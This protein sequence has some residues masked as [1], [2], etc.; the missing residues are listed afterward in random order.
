M[1]CA[2][3]CTDQKTGERGPEPLL[4]LS[5]M[6][7]GRANFG[8]HL[9]SSTSSDDGI[10]TS[11]S[12]L[13]SSSVPLPIV[14]AQQS[15]FTSLKEKVHI[16]TIKHG[17][18]STGG[19]EDQP[20]LENGIATVPS[21]SNSVERNKIPLEKLHHRGDDDGAYTLSPTTITATTTSVAKEDLQQQRSEPMMMMGQAAPTAGSTPATKNVQNSGIKL[22]NQQLSSNSSSQPFTLSKSSSVKLANSSISIANQVQAIHIGDPVS[23]RKSR[24]PEVTTTS[25]TT[26]TTNNTT[27]SSSYLPPSPKNHAPSANISFHVAGQQLLYDQSKNSSSDTFD[28]AITTEKSNSSLTPNGGVKSPI[29]RDTLQVS[30]DNQKNQKQTQKFVEM[31]NLIESID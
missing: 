13:P 23:A 28:A 12:L 7:N 2:T 20:L 19:S 5:A 14:N 18:S 16:R 3:I 24:R 10:A 15:I 4:T 6:R 29:L 1:R 9:Y 25:N 22:K 17:S 11:S 27:S 31:Q 30:P 21:G 8:I 26:S